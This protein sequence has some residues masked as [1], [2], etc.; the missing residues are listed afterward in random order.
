MEKKLDLEKKLPRKPSWFTCFF[1][2]L[3]NT[4]LSGFIGKDLFFEKKYSNRFLDSI[5]N[6]FVL[7]I[8]LLPIVLFVSY[9][10]IT[11]PTWLFVLAIVKMVV[12]LYNLVIAT[13][14]A[15]K[16]PDSRQTQTKSSEKKQ[17]KAEEKAK[18]HVKCYKYAGVFYKNR[19]TTLIGDFFRYIGTKYLAFL[20]G[21]DFM[22]GEKIKRLDM[23]KYNINVII[24]MLCFWALVIPCFFITVPT[25]LFVLAI[26]AAV[27]KLANNFCVSYCKRQTAMKD[28]FFCKCRGESIV[29][30]SLKQVGEENRADV[31][32]F[33]SISSQNVLH[34]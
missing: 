15:Q 18:N 2:V 27:V 34:R 1:K 30:A 33:E 29:H 26:V 4:F 32:D 25:W 8:K 17:Q 12:D 13:N 10:L 22:Y 24:Y 16:V 19:P 31:P 9:F 28:L 3:V 11:L 5:S 14:M 23:A 7:I 21:K 20:F 6:I